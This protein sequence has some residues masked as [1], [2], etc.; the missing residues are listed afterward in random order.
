LHSG[1][2]RDQQAFERLNYSPYIDVEVA[3]TVYLGCMATDER[4]K[5]LRQLVSPWYGRTLNQY[6]HDQDFALKCSLN[7]DANPIILILDPRRLASAL[8][9]PAWPD[10]SKQDVA[11][12][13]DLMDVVVKVDTGQYIVDVPEDVLRSIA[14][15]QQVMNSANCSC[16]V[17][18]T[19]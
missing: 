19:I 3:A 2:A 8:T 9:H 17:I 1:F 15:D 11:S 16:H 5:R 12:V 10:D 7:L 6:R 4:V 14:L 13:E 18:P